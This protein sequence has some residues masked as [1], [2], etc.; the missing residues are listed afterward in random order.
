[1]LEL[2]GKYCLHVVLH[3]SLNWQNEEQKI[4]IYLFHLF[5]MNDAH[6]SASCVSHN[7]PT[8]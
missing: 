3:L 4:H 6:L 1:M 8:G 2:D 7:V 5:Y